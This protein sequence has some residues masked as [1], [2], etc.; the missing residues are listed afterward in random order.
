MASQITEAIDDF[1]EHL[2]KVLGRSKH[3]VSAYRRDLLDM[4][5]TIDT[6][7]GFTLPAVRSW[8]AAAVQ[9]GL[10]R[11]TLARRTA[12]VRAF[13]TWAYRQGHL[14][15]DVAA[16][17]VSPKV[18]RKLPTIATPGQAA[19]LVE[20]EDND[21]PA[22]EQLRDHAIL[23]TLYAT[24]IRVSELCAL[25]LDDI[26][27]A[28]LTLKVTGKGNKQR[29]VPFGQPAAQ[30]LR[31][32]IE[33]ARPEL[34]GPDSANAVFL[35]S[36]GKPINDRQVRRIVQRAGQKVGAPRLSPHGLR[37]SAATHLLEGGADLR[38]VQEMLGHSS[39]N[40]TQIYT[41]VTAQRLKK[42][43]EQAHP[44]A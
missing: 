39:L 27:W 6:F 32:W 2:D 31:A 16:R 22:T 13:S 8:L 28:A 20:I 14:K 43:Y 19:E 34:A 35:G 1:A 11:S 9:R 33:Q 15:E 5:A 3:T 24:G 40:T 44:R 10:A 21:R 42:V 25:Q 18:Q 38:V 41:H 29:V 26:D 23:E 12:A 17:L 4:E 37:H 30:A 7:A 36:R